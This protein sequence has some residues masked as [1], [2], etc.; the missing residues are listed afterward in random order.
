M[1]GELTRSA[2][3]KRQTLIKEASRQ[4][5]PTTGFLTSPQSSSGELPLLQGGIDDS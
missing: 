5:N 4:S 1:A 2:G 3:Q